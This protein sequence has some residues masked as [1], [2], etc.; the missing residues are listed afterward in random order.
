MLIDTI[1]ISCCTQACWE[2]LQKDKAFSCC[3][4]FLLFAVL[5]QFFTAWMHTWAFDT[6]RI[7]QVDGL[8]V[9]PLWR[10]V[11]R[12]CRLL[13]WLLCWA[14]RLELYA[15]F[16][17]CWACQP[18]LVACLYHSLKTGLVSSGWASCLALGTG[19]GAPLQ[20]TP[21]GEE[22]LISGQGNGKKFWGKWN[23]WVRQ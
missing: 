7:F 21:S 17:K 10:C 15:F 23:W 5:P 14:L 4:V 16:P 18:I 2:L 6:L 19:A 1:Y 11:P 22:H 20:F 9:P 12:M 8:T 13:H 3:P